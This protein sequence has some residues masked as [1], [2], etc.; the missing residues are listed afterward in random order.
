MD[1]LSDLLSLPASKLGL[2]GLD[3]GGDRS[4][5]FSNPEERI[6]C[7]ALVSGACFLVVDGVPDP[8]LDR[9]RRL[10]FASEAAAFA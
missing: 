2:G 8:V 3:V 7:Y 9:R 5:A 10:R 4:I 1:P 6:K